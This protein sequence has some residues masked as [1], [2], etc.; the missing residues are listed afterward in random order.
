MYGLW[1]LGL[2]Q[3]R[4]GRLL[5]TIGGVA[6]TV[7][8]IACLGA[9]LR[10]SAAEMTARSIAQVPVDWQIQMLPGADAA[11]V[12]AAARQA[13]PVTVSTQVGYADVPGF[14]SGAG[15]TVQTTGA[16][17]VLGIEPDYV[18]RF[19]DQIRWLL[20]SRSGILVAQQTAANLHVTVDD[21]VV[22]HRYQAPDVSLA[23]SG[24]VELPNADSMFQ[25]IG[26]SAGAAPQA[27]PDNVLILPAA[28][29]YQTFAPQMAAR[30]DTVRTQLHVGIDHLDLPSDP[31]AASTIVAERGRNFESRVAGT[32]LLAN[33]LAARLDA[34]REDALYAR[35]VFLFLGAPGL[36]LAILLTLTVAASGR[37]ARRQD[38]ALLRL[39][40]ATVETVLGLAAAEAVFVGFF[41]A[42]GGI[43]LGEFASRVIL[44]EGLLRAA[45][46]PSLVISAMAGLVISLAAVLLPAWR[47]VRLSTVVSARQAVGRQ[48]PR[49]WVRAYLDFIL[50]AIAGASYWRSAAAGYQ[51]V[52]APEGVRA[53]S[54]DYAAFLA[55]V[56]LW[57]GLGLL[58]ARL[59][60]AGL[61]RGRSVLAQILAVLAGP[62]ASTVAA[63]FGRQ[64]S[65]LTAGIAMTALA[66]AFAA[67][68]A[69]FNA[70]YEAQ[71]RV[72]AELTNGADVTVIGTTSAPASNSLEFLSHLFG[73][74]AA[75]PMQH[76]FAYVGTDLQDLYGIDAT[77]IGSATA[78][79]GAYFANGDAAE[80]LAELERTLDGVLVSQETVNDYQLSHGDSIN[81]R[82]QNVADHQYHMVPFRIVGVVREFPIA[83]KDSFLVANAAYVAEQT[84]SAASEIVLMRVS[85]D[86]ARVARAA[87]GVTKDLPGVKVSQ[88]GDAVALIGSSLTAVD[89]AGLTRLELAFALVMVVASAGLVLAL[90]FADRDRS[91]AVLVALG[92]TPRQLGAFVWSEAALVVV[93]GIVI[94]LPA[95]A[96]IA[97]M[98]VKLLTGVFDPPP[99]ALSL[100]FPYLA[101]LVVTASIAAFLAATAEATRSRTHVTEKLRGER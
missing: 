59:V 6:L 73:V 8:F 51:I 24:I 21:Q 94:G 10:S 50:L 79:S 17:K 87:R 97:Y 75:Q 16:G 54:V 3:S 84:G 65:R 4:S 57:I 88:I 83:P 44:H 99:E 42:L 25:A 2:L 37:D 66:F 93:G 90:G 31:L 55:P 15:G 77:R 18:S 96:L 86:P 76:R 28:L 53:T 9:F 32:A 58:A 47:D 100:P 48:R 43:V 35:V 12:E 5:G 23:V 45:A 7:A 27:P 89:L 46:A 13:A 81:L 101:I 63:A 30:P 74:K 52:L 67:S 20:G 64:S 41:G 11:A 26:V 95:G 22:I 19:P 92:A 40:G 49:L 71:A 62:L 33:N 56:L 98:V 39:R 78:M 61:R 36:I 1:L 34:V 38:Q 70:T 72:D 85:G 29:W 68:T 80:T 82:L 91:F 69:I 14:E 60:G